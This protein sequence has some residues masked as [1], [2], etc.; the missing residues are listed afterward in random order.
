MVL[1]MLTADMTRSWYVGANLGRGSRYLDFK[2]TEDGLKKYTKKFLDPKVKFDKLWNEYFVIGFKDVFYGTFYLGYRWKI[3]KFWLGVE[4]FTSIE[5]YSLKFELGT[6]AERRFGKGLISLDANNVVVGGLIGKFGYYLTPSTAIIAIVGFEVGLHGKY[7]F[8]SPLEPDH[9]D[10]ASIP[11]GGIRLGLEM[12][13]SLNE[14]WSMN[15]GFHK[16]FLSTNIIPI[17]SVDDK[18]K[19]YGLSYISFDKLRY[20]VGMQYYFNVKN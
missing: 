16:T 11:D 8:R 15:L 13:T 10:H 19:D 17:K 18:I 12:K 20:Y 3:N 6:S 5:P 4:A 14:K 7:I 1:L 9:E 2:F